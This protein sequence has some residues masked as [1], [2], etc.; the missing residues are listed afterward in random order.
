M[1]SQSIQLVGENLDEN[2][3]KPVCALL[4]KNLI[5]VLSLRDC[6]FSDKD[7][8]KLMKSVGKTKSLLQLALNIGIVNSEFRI[9]LLAQALAKNH[10]ITGIFIHGSNIG[11]EGIKILY[12]SIIKN[13]TLETL[14]IGDCQLTDVSIPLICELLTPSSDWPGLQDLSLSANPGISKTGWMEFSLA[15]AASTLRTLYL[16]YNKLGDEIA[17]CIII[18]VAGCGTLEI[19]DLEGTGVTQKTATLVL[20]YVES[21][22]VK[23]KKVSFS[24][25]KVQKATVEAIKYH[26]IPVTDEDTEGSDADLLSIT[27]RS[28]VGEPRQKEVKVITSSGE[29]ESGNESDKTI[30]DYSL[31]SEIVEQIDFKK[32]MTHQNEKFNKNSSKDVNELTIH[33]SPG[34][35]YPDE[36]VEELNEVPTY[37]TGIPVTF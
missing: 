4:L 19:L 30:Q 27:T 11:D 21:Y 20:K 6:E 16:D 3:I 10:S 36:Y 17:S 1:S 26:L 14:D 29:A 24:G 34:D 22:T 7:F 9:Q 18:A 2:D 23:L 25:N 5:K 32:A 33:S 13:A 15:L 37:Y 28:S 31:H 8:K 12:K 35:L